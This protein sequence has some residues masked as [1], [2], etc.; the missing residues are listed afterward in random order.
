MEPFLGQIILTAFNT[1]PTGWALCNGQLLPISGNQSLFG[2][3]GTTYGGD[4]H[5]NFA[6]PD[7]RGRTPFHVGNGYSRGAMVGQEQV[8]L[9]IQQLPAHT[10][11][12]KCSTL[13]ANTIEPEGAIWATESTSQIAIYSAGVPNAQMSPISLWSTGGEQPHENRQP[14][15]A[16]NYMIAVTGWIPSPI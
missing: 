3:I 2:L 9:T 16:L 6:L 15:L 4:G 7:L 12:A 10:H 5:T 11:I 8:P 13:S 14:Y 1:V